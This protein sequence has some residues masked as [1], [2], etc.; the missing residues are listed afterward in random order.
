MLK[1]A[2]I[3]VRAVSIGGVETCIDLPGYKLAFDIGRAPDFSVARDLICFTHAH[4]DHLAGVVWHCATRKLRGMS[5]PRYVIGRENADAFRELFEVWRRLDRS[6]LPHELVVLSPG[7][8]L[9]LPRDHFL[10]PFFSPHRAPCQGYAIWSRRQKLRAEFRELPAKEIARA[11][12]ERPGELFETIE[13]PEVAFCGDTL[14]DVVEREEVVRHARL[15]ILEVTFLDERVSIAQARST[16]H[17]HLHELAP[18]AALFENEALLL[19]HFSPRYTNKEIVDAL[20][21][22]LPPALRTR[23]TPLLTART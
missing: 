17:V 8:E 2:G 18:R 6:E 3:D 19:T 15:L 21:R 20:D 9:A 12:I 11:R 1:L 23:C 10:R 7:E 22:S 5:P 4:V 13:I 14:I 16:G